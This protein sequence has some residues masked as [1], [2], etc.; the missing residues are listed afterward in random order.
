MTRWRVE[1]DAAGQ[2][3]DHAVAAALPGVSIAAAKRL[4]ATGAVAIDGRPAR[5]G[6]HLT[7][8]QTVEIDD[9]AA[10][11]AERPARVL[12]DPD[13]AV[14]VL[15]VDATMVAIDK[16]AGIASHPLAP[17]QLGTAANAVCARFPECASASPDAR[18]GGLVHRLDGGTSGVLIAARSAEAWPLLRAALG[19]PDCEKTYLAEVVGSPP[20]AG[21]ETGSIGRLGRR[22]ARVRVGAGRH[23]QS[24][25]TSW[26]VVERR[27][28]TALVRAVLQAGRPHQVRA[29]LAAA[30]HPIVGDSTYGGPSGR[31]AI[32]A[33]DGRGGFHLHAASVRFRHPSSGEVI[34]IEAPPPG[35]A[36]IRA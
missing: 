33:D 29:H 32:A 6:E 27:A 17:R 13:L 4:L 24:A 15:Y 3:V 9:Q 21:V 14:A 20:E 1:P 18:E 35:W 2:R 7:A 8:G 11:D 25:R 26:A 10:G 12:P 36:M 22:G 19:G 5:K 34:L 31:Q 30:G 16:P 28:D 23:L